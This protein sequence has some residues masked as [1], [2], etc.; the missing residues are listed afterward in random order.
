MI[1][2]DGA[3][4][5]DLRLRDGLSFDE[6]AKSVGSTAG[7]IHQIENGNKQPSVKLLKMIADYFKST[8]DEFIIKVDPYNTADYSPPRQADGA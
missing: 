7:M 4:I 3:K 1:I 5:K 6:F 2:V 8:V